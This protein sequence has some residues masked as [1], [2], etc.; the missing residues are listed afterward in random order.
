MGLTV[1]LMLAASLV[2]RP[3]DSVMSSSPLLPRP[4]PL[5]I[6]ANGMPSRSLILSPS[7]SCRRSTFTIFMA[8]FNISPVS[9][10][11][12]RN[13]ASSLHNSQSPSLIA[14]VIRRTD[15]SVAEVSSSSVCRMIRYPPAVFK[16]P[17][18]SDSSNS[19]CG[20]GR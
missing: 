19:S 14:L 1:E 15:C 11:A 7:G 10:I 20:G 16:E 12:A 2:E 18:C 3:S 17:L 13:R 4:L 9:S 5:A 8:S 6:L